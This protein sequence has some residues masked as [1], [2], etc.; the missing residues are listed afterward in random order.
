MEKKDRK[1]AQLP[2]IDL[3]GNTKDKYLV[4]LGDY[5]ELK[6][7]DGQLYAV[8]REPPYPKTFEEC[9]NIL[10]NGDKRRQVLIAVA[11]V[12]YKAD[13]VAMLQTL[14]ACRDAYWKLA[15][16]WRPSTTE[17]VYS[18]RRREGVIRYDY[19]FGMTS[20]LEFPTEEMNKAFYSNFRD[21]I[22]SCKEVL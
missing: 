11:G 6:E 13:I 15:D 16:N 22:Q 8:R 9:S 14:L 1:T 19:H 12:S 18:I 20:V 3:T 5:Y 4:K 21:L 17:K 2:V 7:E 10:V